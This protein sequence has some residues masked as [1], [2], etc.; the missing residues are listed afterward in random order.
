M[1]HRGKLNTPAFVPLVAAEL[2]RLKGRDIEEIAAVTSR[3]CEQL[4][5]WPAL[6]PAPR[7]S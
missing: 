2:A 1:P 7:Q 4:F 6:P 5:G 3:N